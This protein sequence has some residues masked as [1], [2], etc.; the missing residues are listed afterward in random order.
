M[1]LTAVR[2]PGQK[3]NSSRYSQHQQG[4]VFDFIGQFSE[5]IATEAPGFV[6]DRLA[7]ASSTFS[8]AAHDAVQGIVDELPDVLGSARRF[9]FRRAGQ[10]AEPLLK[11]THELLNRCY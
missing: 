2:Q 8:Y 9:A 10:A 7:H 1:A 3:P 6:S 5:C 11:V 4:P